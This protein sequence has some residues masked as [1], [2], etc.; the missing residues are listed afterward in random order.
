MSKNGY[1][2]Y[3]DYQFSQSGDFFKTL[4]MA[5]G[6]ADE[7]NAEKLRK[8]FPEE[9]EAV[10]TFQRIGV[11]AFLEKCTPGNPLIEKMEFEIRI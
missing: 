10:H 11:E 7:I 3:L 2:R 4:F 8:G 5:I 9:V 6:W 1:D